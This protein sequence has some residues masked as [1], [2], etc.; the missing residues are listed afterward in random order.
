MP[1]TPDPPVLE[2]WLGTPQEALQWVLVLL[3]GKAGWNLI[4]TAL[5]PPVKGQSIF[6]LFQQQQEQQ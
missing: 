6:P 1:I 5:P 2:Q 3:M 4:N